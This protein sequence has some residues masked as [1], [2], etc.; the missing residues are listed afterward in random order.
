MLMVVLYP[1]TEMHASTIDQ[2]N[3][4]VHATMKTTPFELTFGQPPRS[5]AF[6]GAR[7]MEED[8]EDT[9]YRGTSG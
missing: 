3:T 4:S 9:R 5:N 6:P 2:L 8:I 1:L 7:V